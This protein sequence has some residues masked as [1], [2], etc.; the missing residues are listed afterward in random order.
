MEKVRPVIEDGIPVVDFET[1]R[2]TKTGGILNVSSSA[3]RFLDH[4]GRPA[5]MLVILRN[6]I[7][8]KQWERKLEFAKKQAEQAN[9]TQSQ[10]LTNMSHELRTPLNAILGFP[11]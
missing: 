10:F 4:E 3:S 9:L 7:E 5:G 8:R 6:I 1:L 2:Y 11:K